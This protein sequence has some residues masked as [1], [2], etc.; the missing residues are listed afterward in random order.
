MSVV[1]ERVELVHVDRPAKGLGAVVAGDP[2]EPD[3]F[4]LAELPQ[5]GDDSL[6]PVPGGRVVAGPDGVDLQQVDMVGAEPLEALL[7]ALHR[8][9]VGAILA[10]RREEHLAAAVFQHAPVV[11]LGLAAV[12]R[13]CR[14]EVGDPQVQGHLG[15]RDGVVCL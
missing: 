1:S 4:L 6:G 7:D 14:V 13:R 11:R 8:P 10:L 15:E 12:V 5:C 3:D 9:V 2:E